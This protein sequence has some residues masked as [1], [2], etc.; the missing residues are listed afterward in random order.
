MYQ[1]RCALQLQMRL[2]FT[3]TSSLQLA[4]TC[5]MHADMFYVDDIH[6]YLHAPGFS[7][8]GWSCGS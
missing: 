2:T 6:D 8:Y 3:V 5:G 7:A 1:E 4:V